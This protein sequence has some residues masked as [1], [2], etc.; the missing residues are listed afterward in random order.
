MRTVGVD[1]DA[2]EVRRRTR[3]P[4]SVACR[5]RARPRTPRRRSA[6]RRGPAGGIPRPVEQQRVVAQRQVR[7]GHA[8]GHGAE[9][10]LV[11]PCEVLL[12]LRQV[13]DAIGA[14]EPGRDGLDLVRRSGVPS[15]VS[16]WKVFGRSHASTTASASSV[17]PRPP[18]ANPRFTT[19]V[20]APASTASSLISSISAS[21]SR[22][23]VVDRHHAR[24]AVR[25]AGC[26]CVRRGCR[27][28]GATHP[29]LRSQDRRRTC[30][31]AT[32]SPG[33]S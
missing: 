23:E 26:R 7:L 32:S 12:G 24:Q 21:V 2:H 4:A 3:A 27:S 1:V 14:V 13:V 8:H 22:R 17:P 20:S 18:S 19:T 30:R 16:W 6:R 28:R 11:H 29:G 10:Q 25:H 5:R 33:R 15:G 31:R 9:P